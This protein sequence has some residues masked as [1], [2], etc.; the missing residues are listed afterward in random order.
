[1]IELEIFIVFYTACFFTALYV[2]LQDLVFGVIT[3]SC[4][5]VL[6]LMWI[7]INPMSTGY[8]IAFLFQA[9]GLMFLL[10]VIVRILR[11]FDFLQKP[12][13]SDLD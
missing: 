7:F 8:T 10:S 3:W 4:W 13:E 11:S 2:I 5:F 9:I 6:G 1:M 12:E